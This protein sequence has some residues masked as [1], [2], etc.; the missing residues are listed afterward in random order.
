MINAMRWNALGTWLLAGLITQPVRCEF[1]TPRSDV[2]DNTESF[3]V[4]DVLPIA[5][6]SGWEQGLSKQPDMVDLWVTWFNRGGYTVKL[7]ANISTKN[8]GTFNWTID[9]PNDKIEG[10]NSESSYVLRFLNHTESESYPPTPEMLPSKGFILHP[11]QKAVTTP[12]PSQ[13]TSSTSP[14]TPSTTPS[15]TPSKPPNAESA[16][17]DP[18]APS[19]TPQTSSKSEPSKKG[20]NTAAIAGGVLGSLVGVALILVGVLALL[21]RKR[22]QDEA[23]EGAKH[24][25]TYSGS[26]GSEIAA[27]STVYAHRADAEMYQA[28]P[29]VELPAQQ[30]Q[31]QSQQGLKQRPEEPRFEVD[32]STPVMT[33]FSE[34]N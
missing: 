15:T 26:N 10:K 29:P 18:A 16:S 14:S 27:G 34:K 23:K 11:S 1:T 8:A 21:K 5:W 17:V 13:T 12:E 4:G 33:R 24:Q 9:V 32:G 25:D 30:H 31:P 20:S 22:K 19:G 6:N 7:K 28:P 2:K 3:T